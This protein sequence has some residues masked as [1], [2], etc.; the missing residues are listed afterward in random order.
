MNNRTQYIVS[1][2]CRYVYV[3]VRRICMVLL[4]I[5]S[6]PIF[7]SHLVLPILILSI[8]LN[9]SYQDLSQIHWE[10]WCVIQVDEVLQ[11]P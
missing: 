11:H 6:Q 8:S 7:E 4:C 1:N 9:D 10:F 5:G 3:L 2:L